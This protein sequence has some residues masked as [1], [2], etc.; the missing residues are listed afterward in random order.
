LEPVIAA[1]KT[2]VAGSRPATGAKLY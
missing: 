1:L 2:W